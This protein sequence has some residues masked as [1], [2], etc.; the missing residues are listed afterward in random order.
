[1]HTKD[2]VRTR[3]QKSPQP[4]FQG[5]AAGFARRKRPENLLANLLTSFSVREAKS[6]K[7]RIPESLQTN[8]VNKYQ[9]MP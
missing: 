9:R 5:G 3:F 2:S 4:P 8:A 7:L 1:M 6:R